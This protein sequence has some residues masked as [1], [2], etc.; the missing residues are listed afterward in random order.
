MK[1]YIIYTTEGNTIA[2]NEDVEIENSQ[3]LGI[4]EGINEKDAKEKLILENLWIHKA[5]FHP[6]NWIIRQVLL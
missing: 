6:S 5:G 3:V 4:I 1:K 2:P